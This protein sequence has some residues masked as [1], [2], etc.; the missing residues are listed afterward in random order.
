MTVILENKEGYHKSSKAVDD[1]FNIQYDKLNPVYNTFEGTDETSVDTIS[2][3]DKML[4][5]VVESKMKIRFPDLWRKSDQ[6]V[7]DHFNIIYD[8]LNPIYKCCQFQKTRSVKI[9]ARLKRSAEEAGSCVCQ[10]QDTLTGRQ[11]Q[12]VDGQW[13]P[14]MKIFVRI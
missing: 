1:H 2:K 12:A 4:E 11:R 3:L 10:A 5:K 7:T 14:R 13:H 9:S 8:K 6:S